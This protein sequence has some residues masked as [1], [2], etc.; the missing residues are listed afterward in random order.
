[1][2]LKKKCLFI[3]LLILLISIKSINAYCI[4]NTPSFSVVV[5]TSCVNQN[6]SINTNV[7]VADGVV[8]NLTNSNITNN[9]F[10]NFWVVNGSGIIVLDVNSNIFHGIT[11]FIKQ[12]DE[13][14]VTL[15][16][17]MIFVPYFLRRKK[18]KKQEEMEVNS[19]G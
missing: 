11:T 5:N 18:R 15:F 19:N 16:L 6:F 9:N 14:L 8:L 4:P 13:A 12:N 3:I 2:I 10:Q 17:I 1:M 7:T